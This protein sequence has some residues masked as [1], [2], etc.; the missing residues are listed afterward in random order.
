MFTP[1]YTGFDYIEG[2]LNALEIE[3]RDDDDKL[4][5]FPKVMDQL[6]KIWPTLSERQKKVFNKW[7]NPKPS[8]SGATTRGVDGDSLEKNIQTIKI[9][10]L[11]PLKVNA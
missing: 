10:H 7:F 1:S 4:L 3:T 11:P 6:A 9:G 2:A 8:S 5:L